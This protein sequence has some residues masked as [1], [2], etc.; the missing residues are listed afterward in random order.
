MS[1]MVVPDMKEYIMYRNDDLW[2]TDFEEPH[3]L[4]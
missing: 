2:K 3:S 4:Q 1:W